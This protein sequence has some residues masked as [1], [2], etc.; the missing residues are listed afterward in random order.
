MNRSVWTVITCTMLLVIICNF[1]TMKAAPANNAKNAPPSPTKAPAPPAAK[2]PATATKRPHDERGVMA[3][4]TA[5]II[6]GLV[7][8]VVGYI[9]QYI[10]S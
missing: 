1:N 4:A 6:L 7:G 2:A 9:M 3:A 5:P 8:Q 10:A